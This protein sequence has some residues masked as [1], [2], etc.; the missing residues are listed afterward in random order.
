MMRTTIAILIPTSI[1]WND[2]DWANSFKFL[3]IVNYEWLNER[4]ISFFRLLATIRIDIRSATIV[5]R[6]NVIPMKGTDSAMDR[7]KS[8]QCARTMSGSESNREK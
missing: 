8:F 4:L 5:M 2:F 3:Y 1:P 6:D 7:E